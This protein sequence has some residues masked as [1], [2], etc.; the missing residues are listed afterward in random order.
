MIGL[1]WCKNGGVSSVM[2]VRLGVKFFG[3]NRNQD[4]VINVLTEK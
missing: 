2:P 3:A 4:R 1:L